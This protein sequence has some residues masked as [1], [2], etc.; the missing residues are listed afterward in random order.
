MQ[1]G[2]PLDTILLRGRWH[3][4]AVARLYLQDGMALIP[5]LRIPPENLPLIQKFAGQTPKTAFCPH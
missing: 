5:S 3:S 4:L 2:L 1:Q